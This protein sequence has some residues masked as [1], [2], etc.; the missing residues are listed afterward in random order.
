MVARAR[1]GLSG[2]SVLKSWRICSAE[3]RAKMCSAT[4]KHNLNSSEVTFLER[5]F[6]RNVARLFCCL[7]L[8]RNKSIAFW[9]LEESMCTVMLFFVLKEYRTGTAIWMIR[10]VVRITH[11][12]DK[13]SFKIFFFEPFFLKT[14]TS[15]G[16]LL[17]TTTHNT[18][19]LCFT[20][21]RYL[22]QN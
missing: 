3:E 14:S 7:C 17:L 12:L 8:D 1:T 20:D 13:P 9:W 10:F 18:W 11:L 16:R 22:K 6:S 4:N 2:N 15:A 19:N 5:G 21:T